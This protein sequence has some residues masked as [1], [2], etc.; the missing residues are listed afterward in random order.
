MSTQNGSGLSRKNDSMLTVVALLLGIVAGIVMYQIGNEK[1]L[2]IIVGMIILVFGLYYLVTMPFSSDERDY[3]P[4]T[5]SFRLAWGAL[6]TAVGLLLILD[7]YVGIDAW[8]MLVIILVV[9]IA[10]IVYMFM[11]NKREA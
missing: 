2:L 1:N 10:V 3:L 8:I 9:V 6:L 11:N 4:S 5:R 7:I